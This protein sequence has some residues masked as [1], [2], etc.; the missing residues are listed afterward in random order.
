MAASSPLNMTRRTSLQGQS[1]L[2]DQ[3]HESQQQ[4]LRPAQQRANT[5]VDTEQTILELRDIF[6][7]LSTIVVD[8]GEML[9]RIGLD[10]DETEKSVDSAQSQLLQYLRGISSDRGLILKIFVVLTVSVVLFFVFLF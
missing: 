4:L 10:I 2:Q 5:W 6:V 7:Q 8:Q 3:M 9:Q 1:R